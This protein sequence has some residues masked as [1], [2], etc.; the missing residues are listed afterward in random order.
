ML[1]IVS[2]SLL[3]EQCLE[4]AQKGDDIV[5]IEDDTLILIKAHIPKDRN[6]IDYS[7]FVELVIKH[8]Q[9]LT[10]F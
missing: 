9:T 8:S 5:L 7:Q 10:W 6:L 1:H 3:F 4:Y 2:K